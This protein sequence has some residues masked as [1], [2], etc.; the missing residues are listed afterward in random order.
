MNWLKDLVGRILVPALTQAVEQKID[1][2]MNKF[3]PLIVH[4]V[5]QTITEALAKFGVTAEDKITDAIPGKLDDQII[6]PL[7]RDIVGKLSGM[8]PKT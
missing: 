5:V 2:Q 8:F 7:V 1:E 4:V 3:L 6:D